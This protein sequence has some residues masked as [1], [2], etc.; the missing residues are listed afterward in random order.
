MLA[1]DNSQLKENCCE[2][3]PGFI[4]VVAFTFDAEDNTIA[5]VATGTTYPAGDSKKKLVVKVHDMFGKE[6]QGTDAAPISLA[7]LNTAKGINVTATLVT[8]NGLVAD[9]GAYN[10][11]NIAAGATLSQ[12]D[13]QKR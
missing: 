9:G 2:G 12:W 13:K 6:V 11:T 5:V 7:T 3:L 10:I 8:T 4:P 1:I